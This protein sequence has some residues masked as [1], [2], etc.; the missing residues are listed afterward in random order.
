MS[1]FA[2]LQNVIIICL[3]TSMQNSAAPAAA[4]SN[5]NKNLY[6]PLC[7][8]SSQELLSAKGKETPQHWQIHEHG[9]L[10]NAK[11]VDPQA[12]CWAPLPRHEPFIVTFLVSR[13]NSVFRMMKGTG[14]VAQLIRF[15]LFKLGDLCLNPALMNSL[16]WLVACSCNPPSRNAETGGILSA[17]WS[18]D[19][20]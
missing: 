13:F 7:D 2:N 5:H 1:L 17:F 9:N 16:T 12:S 15:L 18:A 3:K 4:P 14:E 19:L 6:G 20:T 11:L 8:C 10:I